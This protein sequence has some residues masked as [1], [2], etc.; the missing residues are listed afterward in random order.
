[1]ATRVP[2]YSTVSAQGL[3][4]T[5]VTGEASVLPSCRLTPATHV[6]H[7]WP[8]VTGVVHIPFPPSVSTTDDDDD[9]S[10]GVRET[11]LLLRQNVTREEKPIGSKDPRVASYKIKRIQ[12]R[13]VLFCVVVSPSKNAN[14]P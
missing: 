6:V 14:N 12:Q 5:R 13:N 4:S 9:V 8:R 3:G 10:L 7:L 1:M 11:L 2:E